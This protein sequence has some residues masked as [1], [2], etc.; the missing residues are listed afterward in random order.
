MKR[1][2]AVGV[3]GVAIAACHPA[4][5]PEVLRQWQSRQLYTCCNIHY[6]TATI[7]DANYYVGSLLPFGTAAT[8][9]K[10]TSDS[11]T[12]AAGGTALTLAQSYGRDQ[13]NSQQY[14][15][16]I[17]VDTDPH[18]VFNTYSKQVQ[19]AITEA[20]V[21]RGMT[22]PQVL[23]SLGYPPTHRTASTNL[24][25]WTYWYNQWV[26]YQVNFDDSGKVAN[27]V[28]TAPTNNQPIIAPTPIP[29]APVHKIRG[30]SK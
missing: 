12:F 24:N 13:E 22:K 14:F 16:K 10:M 21:E 8:V 4:V 25:I 17:F 29:A 20:R 27:I 11:V 9:Q 26:T 5:S 2:L 7:S 18:T 23:M 19:S 28:G 30:K 3:L 1:M 6:E 15:A